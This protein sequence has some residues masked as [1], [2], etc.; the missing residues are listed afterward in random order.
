MTEKLKQAIALIKAGDNHA[1]KQLLTD[2]LNSDPENEMAWIWMSTVMADNQQRYDCLRKAL[3]IN[4]HNK[5]V[6]EGLLKLEW[7]MTRPTDEEFNRLIADLSSENGRYNAARQLG[8]LGD[9]R[10]IEPLI[11]SLIDP[12]EYVRWNAAIALG[13]IGDPRAIDPLVKALREA[14]DVSWHV[15]HALVLIGREA[16]P[17]LL[18][19]LRDY[20]Y[21]ARWSAAD[22]LAALEAEEA[23]PLLRANLD[24][25]HEH[26]RFGARLALEELLGPAAFSLEELIDD[27][28]HSPIPN[29][30]TSH[31]L[32]TVHHIGELGD[33]Q[34]LPALLKGTR[35]S[36]VNLTGTNISDIEYD[37]TTH[38]PLNFQPK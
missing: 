28:N 3:T 10:A 37:E 15:A 5:V 16:I 27:L 34:A 1:G 35:L 14:A 6:K 31:W 29:Q 23:G 22:A 24:D 17:A 8:A 2:I 9:P 26:A 18:R 7:Q 30:S 25:P 11:L 33:P 38:W 12:D 36:L 13:K 32:T 20:D 4:P 19:A 21:Q